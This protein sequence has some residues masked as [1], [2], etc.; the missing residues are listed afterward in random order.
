MTVASGMVGVS[1][2][3]MPVSQSVHSLGLP[4]PKWL[5]LDAL[6]T[7]INSLIVS[8]FRC[9]RSLPQG[10][11]LSLFLL[12]SQTLEAISGA[13]CWLP[14]AVSVCACIRA[15]FVFI[16]A[17]ES[18]ELLAD[19]FFQEGLSTLRLICIA[20]VRTLTWRGSKYFIKL[21]V[22]LKLFSF[23]LVVNLYYS[24]VRGI[25]SEINFLLWCGR[26]RKLWFGMDLKVGG[27][28]HRVQ[29]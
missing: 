23:E 16:N 21:L 6:K 4:V 3:V 27:A 22:S 5:N 8:D 2:R 24:K 1:K 15:L 11:L 12:V 18:N 26:L 19:W 20:N 10:K 7:W 28:R 29:S 17:S 14:I 9:L 13:Y 25:T